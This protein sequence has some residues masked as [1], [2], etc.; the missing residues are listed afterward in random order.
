MWD[1]ANAEAPL[2]AA[3]Q[4]PQNI[5]QITNRT[6][7]C[8]LGTIKDFYCVSNNMSHYIRSLNGLSYRQWLAVA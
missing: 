2:V 1:Y 5:V 3:R 7:S 8:L 4:R 6:S